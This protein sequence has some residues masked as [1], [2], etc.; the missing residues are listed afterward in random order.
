MIRR[1][2]RSFS[3]FAA[4]AEV[5]AIPAPKGS[6]T[7]GRDVSPTTRD[8]A[9]NNGFDAAGGKSYDPRSR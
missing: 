8:E 4:H 6:L 3:S 5:H 2:Q 7:P 9:D 1:K